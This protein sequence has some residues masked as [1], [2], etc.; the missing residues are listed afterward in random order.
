M[1]RKYRYFIYL[2]IFYVVGYCFFIHLSGIK[3][4]A[5]RSIFF[6]SVDQYTSDSVTLANVSALIYFPLLSVGEKPLVG[7][8]SC[9]EVEVEIRQDGVFYISSKD[10]SAFSNIKFDIYKPHFCWVEC[11]H[12]NDIYDVL[13]EPVFMNPNKILVTVDGGILG[14]NSFELTKKLK[15]IEYR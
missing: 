1:M 15:V 6:E 7:E 4:L 10:F 5:N 14:K 9:E 13:I 12:E 11:N 3:L 2:F 8:W